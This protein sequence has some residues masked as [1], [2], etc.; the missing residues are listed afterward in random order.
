MELKEFVSKS[1]QDIS[2]G[3]SAG[4]NNSNGDKYRVNSD[5][6]FDLAVTASNETSLEGDITAKAGIKVL[7]INADIEA[8][9]K[10]TTKTVSRIHFKVQRQGKVGFAIA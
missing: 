1:L 10:D 3:I 5:I 2:A 6:D 9:S 7:G 4:N 8:I